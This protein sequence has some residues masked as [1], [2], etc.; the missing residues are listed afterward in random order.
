M[1]LFPFNIPDVHISYVADTLKFDV[2]R[3]FSIKLVS[4][5][6]IAFR[7]VITARGLTEKSLPDNVFS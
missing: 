7:S 6:V 4:G 1:V 5:N 3:I 2:L